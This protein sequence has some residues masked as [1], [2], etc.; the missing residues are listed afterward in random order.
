[1][2]AQ[3]DILHSRIMDEGSFRVDKKDIRHPDLSDQSMIKCHA[4][5]CCARKGEPLVFPVM[6][7][8]KSHCK[9]LDR[10]KKIPIKTSRNMVQDGHS[11][12][13]VPGLIPMVLMTFK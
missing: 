11:T 10:E 6:P 8:I 4:F 3:H 2:Y 1:M 12:L 9:V 7:E 13:L 5:V